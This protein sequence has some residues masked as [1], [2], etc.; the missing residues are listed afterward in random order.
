MFST[1]TEKEEVALKDFS[2]H[3]FIPENPSDF[4]V[5]ELIEL[6]KDY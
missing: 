6:F 2:Q 5:L 3:S 1:S 4:M